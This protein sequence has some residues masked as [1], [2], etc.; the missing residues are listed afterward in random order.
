MSLIRLE[1]VSKSFAGDPVLEDI[2]FRVEDDEKIGLIGRNGTGKSTIFKMLTGELEADSGVIER[3]KRARIAC[4]AQLPSIDKSR[5]LFDIA[6]AQFGNLVELENRLAELEAQL[7]D[8]SEESLAAYGSLQDEFTVRGGYEFRSR[9]KRVL[10]GLGF[11]EDEFELPYGALSGGQRTRLLLALVLLEDADLLLLDEPENHLDMEARE[12]LEEFLKEWPRAFVIISHDRHILNAVTL[13]TVEVIRCG[14]Q[15]FSGNY[16][17]YAK[18]RERLEGDQ[19]RAFKKQQE[20][21]ARE[22]SW[23]NRFRY[24]NTKSRQVQSRIKRLEKL[25][26]VDAPQSDEA[27]ARFGLG[28][29]VRSGQVVLEA[30]HLSMNYPGLTLYKDLSFTVERGERVGIIGPNGSGKTTLLRQLNRAL[31]GGSGEVKT[32]H[33]VALGYYD[34]QHDHLVA[35]RDVLTEVMKT[36][37]EWT[38]EQLRTFLGRFLFRGEDVFKPVSALSG[39]ERSRVAIAKLILSE[40]NVLLLDEP[41]NHLDLVSRVALEESLVGF[42]GSIVVVSHDRALVDRLVDKLVIISNGQGSV[43]LGNYSHYRWKQGA[44]AV[45]EKS[46]R[47]AMKIRT[48]N[49]P[50]AKPTG[51]KE[52]RKRR[53]RIDGLESNIAEMEALA[54]SIELQL[55]EADPRNYTELSKLMNELDGVRNDLKGLYEEWEELAGET[56]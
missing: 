4:L 46:P 22:E 48:E 17:A 45:Q 7:H 9:A 36:R 26:L 38:T 52:D 16:E 34:Q 39:G 37:P 50:L 30:K 40:A 23:I 29:V 3:N 15:G 28:E 12:W 49:P 10:T 14:L 47:T 19:E 33:K 25:D 8:H 44:A 21:I 11:R 51:S 20:F 24:K 6:L 27:T 35:E 54:D 13:R 42:P 32:G 55:R 5:A 53:K 43:H 18:E 41:T 31:P 56:A 2:N 1:N